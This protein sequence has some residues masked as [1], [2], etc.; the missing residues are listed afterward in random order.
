M[1]SDSVLYAVFGAAGGGEG[2]VINFSDNVMYI[3][4][5]ASLAYDLRCLNDLWIKLRLM[6]DDMLASYYLTDYGR[7]GLTKKRK[8]LSFSI[9]FFL[10]VTAEVSWRY[11]TKLTAE[12]TLVAPGH[13][14]EHHF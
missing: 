3:W 14:S 8:V 5:R 1:Q 4:A 9:T 7:K 2:E 10:N 12:K 13:L 6:S 11:C